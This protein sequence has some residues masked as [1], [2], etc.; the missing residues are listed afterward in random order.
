[1]RTPLVLLGVS[2]AVAALTTATAA[3]SQFPTGGREIKHV[4]LISVDGLHAL[5]LTN[6]VRITKIST[7]AA[8][9]RH[10]VTYA[11]NSNVDP[12]P[13]RS[14]GWPPWSRA[15]RPRPRFWSGTTTPT[16]VRLSPPAKPDGL[17]NPGGCACP[18][19]VGHNVAWDEAVDKDLTRLDGGGGLNPDFLGRDPKNGCRTLLPHEVPAR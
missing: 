18:G 14:P 17:G 7:L 19:T 9:S 13:T 15:A 8:L 2:L 5:D 16:I 12:C 3:D 11:N 10:G 1:M 6:Y 4:L